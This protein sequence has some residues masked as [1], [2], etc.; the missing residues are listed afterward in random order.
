[1]DVLG[2]PGDEYWRLE[3]GNFTRRRR[4]YC[5]SEDCRILQTTCIL[6]ARI[7]RAEAALSQ[8]YNKVAEWMFVNHTHRL[9]RTGMSKWAQPVATRSLY[10]YTGFPSFNVF[11]FLDGTSRAIGRPGFWQ[12][13]FY[14]G[15][16][17]RHCLQ[18]LSVTAPDGMI[19]FTY[20]PTNGA[21]QDNWLVNESRLN[22]QLERLH[23]LIG[24]GGTPFFLCVRR[25]HLRADGVHP[26]MH[27]SRRTDV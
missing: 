21:H 3:T 27:A 19:L 1:M 18:Y 2:F 17:R 20:G 15:H 8:L 7:Q 14:S 24:D 25:S 11:G 6:P 26:E 4:C 16:K 10:A 22:E 5:T 9:L 12:R 23:M 13:V